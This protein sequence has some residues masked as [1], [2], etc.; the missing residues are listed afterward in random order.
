[1]KGKKFVQ[2]ILYAPLALGKQPNFDI[3][4]FAQTDRTPFQR[5]IS[6][7]RAKSEGECRDVDPYENKKRG[8]AETSF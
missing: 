5:D 8:G 1:M 2:K 4:N 7:D 6:L 3:L